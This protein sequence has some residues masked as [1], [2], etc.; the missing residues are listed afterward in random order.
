L[1]E[2][3][4]MVQ[5]A[6]AEHPS[7][8]ILLALEVDFIPGQEEWIRSLRARH[9]WDYFIGSV[10]YV[11]QGW[12]ID[13]PGRRDEWTQRDTWDVWEAYFQRLEQAA[14]SGLFQIIGHADLCKKFGNY[15][16]RDWSSLLESFV[17]V[18]S[19]S[20]CA[21]ELNTAGLRKDC[22][23]IYPSPAF[24]G[25]AAR[26]RVPITFGSDAHDPTEVGMDF[27]AAVELARRCGY[28]HSLR[29]AQGTGTAIPL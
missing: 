10:H 29:L 13:N 2:Y 16:V 26:A 22:R 15:P 7:L 17:G 14:G 28:T 3:V 9:P 23:E 8:S 19:R 6:R 5:A 4:E 27:S 25:F 21:I 11:T 12:D 20:G 1:D 24:L 18:A